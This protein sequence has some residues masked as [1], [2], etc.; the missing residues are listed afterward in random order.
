[1]LVVSLRHSNGFTLPVGMQIARKNTTLKQ[2]LS[3]GQ[4]V[5]ECVLFVC[6]VFVYFLRDSGYPAYICVFTLSEL[7]GE[8][9]WNFSSENCHWRGWPHSVIAA[10]AVNPEQL[11][12]T[13]RPITEVLR[14]RGFTRQGTSH[15]KPSIKL[16]N[17]WQRV[18]WNTTNV[19]KRLHDL[20]DLINLG[21][22]LCSQF[23][24]GLTVDCVCGMGCST[25]R[26][27]LHASV[28][29]FCSEVTPLP[30]PTCRNWWRRR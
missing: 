4:R 12:V 7:R 28:P 10:A 14:S 5:P 29:A 16:P 30:A 13:R 11:S 1:M 18:M 9:G 24:M 20:N 23:S 8:R 15:L 22:F 21:C 3:S 19:I 17:N 26:W 25:A 2:Y 6:S 27:S